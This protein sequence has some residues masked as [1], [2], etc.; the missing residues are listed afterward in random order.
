M[1]ENSRL[2]QAILLSSVIWVL[3]AGYSVNFYYLYPISAKAGGESNVRTAE[4]GPEPPLRPAL[5]VV[6]KRLRDAFPFLANN[7][8][9]VSAPYGN[10]S[11]TCGED[12]GWI[13]AN[14]FRS[15]F[16]QQELYPSEYAELFVAVVINLC[17]QELLLPAASFGRELKTILLLHGDDASLS[18]KTLYPTTLNL[19]TSPF[20]SYFRALQSLA[21]R[22]NWTQIACICPS[23]IPL[24]GSA[25]FPS[26]LCSQLGQIIAS[27][28][29][30][31]FSMTRL[32][33]DNGLANVE[34]LL[35][36]P[37]LSETASRQGLTNG[38][39]IFVTTQ[40]NDAWKSFD[41]RIDNPEN[42]SLPTDTNIWSSL[43]LISEIGVDTARPQVKAFLE[44]VDQRSVQAYNLTR[45]PEQTD[46]M[47]SLRYIDS[48]FLMAQV[49]NRSWNVI[50]KLNARSTIQRVMNQS[51]QLLA[52]DVYVDTTGSL[53]QRVPVFRYSSSSRSW[54]IVI[55]CYPSNMSVD[56]G[57]SLNREWF[58]VPDLPSDIPSCGLRNENCILLEHPELKYAPPVAVVTL[59]LILA[60][61][62]R[63]YIAHRYRYLFLDS[64]TTV[65]LLSHLDGHTGRGSE[66]PQQW[67]VLFEGKHASAKIL[68]SRMSF[69][70]DFATQAANN[71]TF[72]LKMLTI[73]D[74][75]HHNVAIF[76]GVT[77]QRPSA[78]MRSFFVSEHCPRG[79]LSDI[80]RSNS[81]LTD[82]QFRLSFIRDVIEG[83]NFV[84]QSAVHFHGNFSIATCVVDN[85]FTVKI[86]EAGYT[87]LEDLLKRRSS[88]KYSIT[89]AVTPKEFQA[90]DVKNADF[91]NPLRTLQEL[92][93]SCQD[94]SEHRPTTAVL[95]QSIGQLTNQNNTIVE[96][97]MQKVTRH[98]DQLQHVV[99]ER[100]H[101]LTEETHKVDALLR[102]MLPQSIIK[103]LRNQEPIAAELFDSATVLFSDIPTF[104]SFARDYPPL[105]LVEFLNAL[106]T[107]F[108]ET[109][110]RFDAYKVETIN[111]SY[112]VTSG[113]PNRNGHRH[114]C[115]VC[116]VALQLRR[117]AWSVRIASVPE[118]RV[119]LRIGINTGP[120]ATGV[121]G[122]KMPRYCLFGDA[123]NTGSRMESH[124]EP[125]MIHVS[126]STVSVV[127][128][129]NAGELIFEER[130]LIEIKGKGK[131]LT[132][133]LLAHGSTSARY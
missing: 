50:H 1:W 108:D 35:N 52:G 59:L 78:H 58:G 33:L 15:Y 130:G 104:A 7:F 43:L 32:L 30:V 47:E 94:V 76:H 62:A 129:H 29:T 71:V 21:S 74:A 105:I 79:N 28:G 133:W 27:I 46:T 72:G 38:D 115:E 5:D 6:E 26:S 131:I 69:S 123:I 91:Q 20:S 97:L 80:I 111:D 56:W 18:N 95:L 85:H 86:S 99:A 116:A 93:N 100:T 107:A 37:I 17:G 126:P 23:K 60:L 96:R 88:Q 121:V 120:V 90:D 16:A 101:A 124:G 39:H 57:P 75:K 44:E 125:D 2:V 98:A 64:W 13:L 36:D 11:V 25:V 19:N 73:H 53:V 110:A 9:L 40:A 51:Y 3:A 109:L 103:K 106:Y 92:S 22:Y 54:E 41:W 4:G 45:R 127:K 119:K 89:A 10:D 65:Q 31:T 49:L 113:I 77:F 48:Y 117:V 68:F 61:L 128:E 122:T 118:L 42:C 102:E 132:Y 66:E 67:D 63:S 84:H 83:L 55:W 87:Q 70:K 82:V 112:L 14:F 81:L 24:D 12:I 34:S 8:S 114:A